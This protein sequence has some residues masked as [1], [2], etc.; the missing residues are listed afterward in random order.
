MTTASL[1]KISFVKVL[2][3]YPGFVAVDEDSITRWYRFC[4]GSVIISY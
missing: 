4:L 3:N 2:W 1:L